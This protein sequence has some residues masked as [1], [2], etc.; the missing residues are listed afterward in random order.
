MWSQSCEVQEQDQVTIVTGELVE[1]ALGWGG[2]GWGEQQVGLSEAVGHS[3]INLSG[4]SMCVYTCKHS[5][6]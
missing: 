3:H 4:G 6:A 5:L 2:A 1:A